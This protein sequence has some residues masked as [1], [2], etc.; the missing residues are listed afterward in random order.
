[1]ASF[2][3]DTL[4]RT[5][6]GGMPIEEFDRDVREKCP[7]KFTKA[8]QPG[9]VDQL[10]NLSNLE[11]LLNSGAIHLGSVDV[12]DH[13]HLIR[14][15]DMYRKSGKS[16]V[17]VMADSIRRGSTIRIRDVDK[18]DQRLHSF[19]GEIQRHFA[20]Q[21]QINVYLTPPNMAGFPP[22]F[23]ITDV[24]VVQCAGSKAWKIFHDYSDKIE[25]PGMDTNWDPDRFKPSGQAESITLEPGDVLYLP[26]GVMHQASCQDRES[27][28]LTIS[29]VPLTFADLIAKALKTAAESDT[30]FRRR[31]PWSIE[32]ANGEKEGLLNQTRELISRLASRMDVDTLLDTERRAYR[33][34]VNANS[35][36]EL[37]AAVARPNQDT[38]LPSSP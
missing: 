7:R 28:H 1:M 13:G 20:A 21:S 24:F 22:H 4:A 35:F 19:T 14:L 25:L 34:Q 2:D 38:V 26:R 18:F 37:E 23:D 11:V 3:A 8:Y 16:V 36:G 5:L 10:C 9:Q 6:V 12:F 17:T 29:I 30:D 31:V 27:L 15:G 32:I 33:P